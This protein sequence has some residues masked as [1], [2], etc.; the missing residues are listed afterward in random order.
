MRGCRFL[1]EK[2]TQTLTDSGVFSTKAQGK[3]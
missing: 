1:K 2:M 3:R